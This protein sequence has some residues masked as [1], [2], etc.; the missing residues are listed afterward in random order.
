[1]LLLVIFL[2]SV[3]L[4]LFCKHEHFVTLCK[5]REPEVLFVGDSIIQALGQ[6]EVMHTDIM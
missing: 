1:M 6:T 3:C 5:E 2:R 4:F